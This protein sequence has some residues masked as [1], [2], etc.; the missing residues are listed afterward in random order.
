MRNRRYQVTLPEDLAAEMKAA[1]S[2]RGATVAEFI[3][4][5][6]REKL[7]RRRPAKPTD[8]FAWMDGIAES[9]DTDL[10]GRVDE[11][12]YRDARVH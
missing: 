10:A 11:I 5:A 3:R 6:I 12:L 1:A 2:R 8:L 7:R 9:Q 4:Q